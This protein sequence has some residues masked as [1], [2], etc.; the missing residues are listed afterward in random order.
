MLKAL[1]NH[2]LENSDIWM[3]PMLTLMLFSK[4]LAIFRYPGPWLINVTHS[5]LPRSIE[6]S[7]HIQ[8]RLLFVIGITRLISFPTRPRNLDS[9]QRPSRRDA[10]RFA[11]ERRGMVGR[12]LA[13]LR[14]VYVVP[15]QPLFVLLTF[16]LAS[17][18]YTVGYIITQLPG[19]LILSRFKPRI[20]MPAMM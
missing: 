20:I 7:V 2:P 1:F 18:S 19:S 10:E 12:N 13:V 14:Y 17:W 4:W 5:Q 16:R 15:H 3:L 6:R 9:D 8:L 11:Y